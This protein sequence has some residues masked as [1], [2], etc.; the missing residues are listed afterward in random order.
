[1]E[2][3]FEIIDKRH[4]DPDADDRGVSIQYDAP[5]T[6]EGRKEMEYRVDAW[7]VAVQSCMFADES[8]LTGNGVVLLLRE[9]RLV[10]R[11]DPAFRPDTV[12]YHLS[13]AWFGDNEYQGLFKMLEGYNIDSRVGGMTSI[14]GLEERTIVRVTIE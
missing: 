13:N 9:W 5:L 11:R 3:S 8:M 7:C 12:C 4:L 10:G 14:T 2:Y 6:D 1:M